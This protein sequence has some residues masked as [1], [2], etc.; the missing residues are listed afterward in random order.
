VTCGVY[1]SGRRVGEFLDTRMGRSCVVQCSATGQWA[2][3]GEPRRMGGV[4][5]RTVWYDAIE[6]GISWRLSAS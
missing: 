5:R 6:N 2:E 3:I 1:L 4:A